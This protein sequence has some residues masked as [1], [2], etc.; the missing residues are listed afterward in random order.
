MFLSLNAVAIESANQKS[1]SSQQNALSYR[2]WAC[3]LNR[4][5]FPLLMV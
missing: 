5:P 2:T 3:G 1:L 4:G